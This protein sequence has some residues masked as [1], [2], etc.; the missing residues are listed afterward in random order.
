MIP[1]PDALNKPVRARDVPVATPITGVTNVGDVLTTN[2]VPVPV[3]EAI[4]VAFPVEVIGPVK[5]AFVVTVSANR[6]LAV[7]R[8]DTSVTDA[9]TNGAVPV[10]TVDLNE[11]ATRELI[12]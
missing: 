6:V 4:A 3:W 7:Y 9:T 12:Y 1:T 11:G 5:L 10:A 8:L 2:T